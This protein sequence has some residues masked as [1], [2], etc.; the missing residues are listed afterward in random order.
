MPNSNDGD[1]ETTAFVINC[2]HAGVP[3][4]DEDLRKAIRF[5]RKVEVLLGFTR[6]RHYLSW[7]DI[8]NDLSTLEQWAKA[9]SLRIR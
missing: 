5:L 1:G 6:E 4:G 9:R 8:R 7:Q 3:V 2:L